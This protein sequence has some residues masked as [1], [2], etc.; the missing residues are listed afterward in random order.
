VGTP[1]Q[2]STGTLATGFLITAD[3]QMG[4]TV[5]ISACQP[6][7]TCV[8]LVDRWPRV[9]HS[10]AHIRTEQS[11]FPLSPASAYVCSPVLLPRAPYPSRLSTIAPAPT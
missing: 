11:L 9:W 1:T 10:Q 2:R 3:E 4:M 5:L 7:H 8:R 6:M